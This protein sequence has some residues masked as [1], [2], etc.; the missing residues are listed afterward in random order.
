M[1][2]TEQRARFEH[3]RK[4]GQGA[5]GEVELARDNDIRRTVAVKRVLGESASAAALMRFATRE[6]PVCQG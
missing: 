5:M 3:V 1:T 4:L 2:V 6:P